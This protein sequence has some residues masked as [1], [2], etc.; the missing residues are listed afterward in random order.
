[1]KKQF[2]VTEFYYQN[3]HPQNGKIF[4]EQSYNFSLHEEELIM[5]KWI[6]SNLGGNIKLLSEMSGIYGKKQADF[7]WNGKLWELKTLKSERSI[8]SA[9]R[10]AIEQIYN[11]PGGVILDFGKNKVQLPLIE[12]AVKSRIESSC[13]FKID[14]IIIC[15]GKLRKVLQYL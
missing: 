15:D 10:K 3:A 9:L 7:E 14:I 6:F 12:S 5:A 8:D 1:M 2:D 11:N 4:F 13:R